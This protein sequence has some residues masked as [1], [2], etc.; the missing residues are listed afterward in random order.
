MACVTEYAQ[1]RVV[2]RYGKVAGAGCGAALCR[3]TEI[4]DKM[5]RSMSTMKARDNKLL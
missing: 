3:R 4:L 1:K 2:E 5:E